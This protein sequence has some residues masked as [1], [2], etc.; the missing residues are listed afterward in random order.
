MASKSTVVTFPESTASTRSQKITIPNLKRVVSV[1]V[2]TGNV[3]HSVSGNDV[4]ISVSAGSYTRYTTQSYTPSKQVSDTRTS[5]TDSFP[6]TI[7]YSDGIYSGTLSK[8]GSSV[9]S[10]S[11]GSPAATKEASTSRSASASG[12]TSCDEVTD[13]A[14]NSLSNT[15][16]YNDGDG[17]TGSLPFYSQNNGSCTR[18]VVNGRTVYR[19][20]VVKYYRGVVSK[21]DTREYK[22]SQ[23][24]SGTVYGQSQVSYTYYYAYTVTVTYEDNYGQT[25]TLTEPASGAKLSEG[26]VC[27][28][29]GTT[30][31]TDAGDIVSVYVR[32]NKGT[33]YR[34]NQ[35]SA[36]GV[37]AIPFTRTFTFAGGTLKDGTTAV[38]TQLGENVTHLLEVWSED[39]KGGTS[40]IAERTFTVTLN[41]PPV[42]THSFVPQND[43]LTEDAS[44]VIN[45]TVSDPDGHTV[46]MKYRLNGGSDVSVPINAGEWKITLTPKQLVS[47]SNS[48][49]VT[50]TDAFGEAVIR[51]FTL[52]RSVMK[53][54]LKT[55]HAR[56][57]LSQQTA[58]IKEVLA[59]LQH[60]TGDLTVDGALSIV[61]SGAAESYQTMSKTSAPVLHGIAEAEF[62]GTYATANSQAHLKLTL[63]SN[64]PNSTAAAT[65]LS[66]AI[67]A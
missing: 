6:S 42:L 19:V 44:V 46:T 36:D 61:A 35:T 8:Q 63:V 47:G 21:S 17:F 41:R 25:L 40:I 31:D 11:S 23:S 55:A 18:E 49:V 65:S 59:W 29:T 58:N 56:Y 10:V 50:A 34:I 48:L 27:V 14:L 53:M 7:S 3:T 5:S 24:Y 60:E 26:S 54:R 43:N 15:A 22:Y 52:T 51:T 4:T 57:K 2:N 20:S 62:I 30:L 13:R 12:E 28:V 16:Y 39:N 67:K 37:N 33:S 64:D 9:S 38:S 45:G 32:V 1:A 66:G